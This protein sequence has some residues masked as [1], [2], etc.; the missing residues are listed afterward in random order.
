MGLMGS[1]GNKVVGRSR[2][3]HP[4][5]TPAVLQS[6]NGFGWGSS[7]GCSERGAASSCRL[8]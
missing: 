8:Q 3:K 4:P 7:T 6:L 5:G 1:P 2:C